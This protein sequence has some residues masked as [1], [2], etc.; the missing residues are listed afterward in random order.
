MG[1]HFDG[2]GH[3]TLGYF[4]MLQLYD[5]EH[6]SLAVLHRLPPH[7]YVCIPDV[8]IIIKK[9]GSEAF[10]VDLSYPRETIRLSKQWTSRRRE[11]LWRLIKSGDLSW[12]V[13]QDKDCIELFHLGRVIENKSATDYGAE[14]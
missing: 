9:R 5:H 2:R 1:Q 11:A 10:E 13:W 7:R 4:E 6:K 3:K 12:K 8:K 14:D